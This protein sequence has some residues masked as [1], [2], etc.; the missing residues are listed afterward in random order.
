MGLSISRSMSRDP[1]RRTGA[2]NNG[3]GAT[4]SFTLPFA[5]EARA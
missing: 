5:D 1:Q 3:L 2:K 4:F